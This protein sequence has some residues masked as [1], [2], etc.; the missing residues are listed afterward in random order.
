MKIFYVAV[1]VATLGA[2]SGS[3]SEATFDRTMT[4][5]GRVELHV[6]TGSGNIYLSS[7]TDDQVHVLGR[8]RSSWGCSEERV[9]EIAEHPLIEQNGQHI[10]IGTRH[11]T[12]DNI[13]IDYEIK[14][15]LGVFLEVS[16]G[17]GDIADDGVGENANL[18]TGSGNIHATGLQGNFSVATG[19][20]NI[21]VEQTGEGDVKV[22][23]GSGNVELRELSGGLNVRTGSGTI[24]V[25][26]T[27]TAS[28]QIETGSGKVEFW[29][30]D[31]PFTLDAST[32]SGSIRSDRELLT[33][34]VLNHHRISGKINGG[35]PLVRIETGSGDIRVH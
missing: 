29:S 10:R 32:G 20:G 2:I 21:Y 12:L 35:G 8:V 11:D 16:T 30:G 33:K 26:G 27:P 28:W 24:K 7:G 9:R 19:S 5:R 25:R 23:A 17:S 14:A 18:S 3:A 15:P 13:S 1:A 22:Q 31:A 34:G 6:S 4:V